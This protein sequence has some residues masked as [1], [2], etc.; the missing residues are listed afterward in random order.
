MVSPLLEVELATQR[1]DP[2]P[3]G[4]SLAFSA[5][6]KR[7]FRFF[8]E[9]NAKPSERVE[10]FVYRR[11]DSVLRLTSKAVLLQYNEE[12]AY[13]VYRGHLY[14]R[15]EIVPVEI[16]ADLSHDQSVF[17]ADSFI[18]TCMMQKHGGDVEKWPSLARQFLDM[19]PWELQREAAGH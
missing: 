11:S 12:L 14:A 1:R 15:T 8:N 9:A 7:I 16:F 4:F 13:L 18:R 17:T 3:L 10:T 19:V 2:T 6:S 5:R